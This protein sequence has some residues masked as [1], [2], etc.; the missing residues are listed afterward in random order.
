M[1]LPHLET[2]VKCIHLEE[3]VFMTLPFFPLVHKYCFPFASNFLKDKANRVKI[4]PVIF[5]ASINVLEKVLQ[6]IINNRR[7]WVDQVWKDHQRD[8]QCY[9]EPNFCQ[10]QQHQPGER[11]GAIR[12][13]TY[14]EY[15]QHCWSS[16]T[17]SNIAQQL[18]LAN[19]EGNRWEFNF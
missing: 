11:Q 2:L 13:S 15:S 3:H 9:C 8:R 5:A 10:D 12:Y 14:S 16:N 1:L 17:A 6:R 4:V 18:R 19:T 7:D